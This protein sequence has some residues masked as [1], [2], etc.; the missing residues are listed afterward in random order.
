MKSGF[1]RMLVVFINV[2]CCLPAV[3]ADATEK[4]VS[5]TGAKIPELA[6]FDRV[7][8]DMIRR[9]GFPG[10][11]FA[12]AKDGRLLLAHGYGMADS[13]AGQVMTPDAMF[14]IASLSKPITAAV[15]LKLVAAGKLDLDAKVLNLLSA[16]EPAGKSIDPRWRQISVRQL[17]HHTAGFDRQKSFDP[18]CDSFRVARELGIPSP[19]DQA[20][21]IRL[22]LGRPLDFDPGAKYVYSNF[23]YCLLGRVIEKRTG[24]RYDEATQSLVLVPAGITR[25]RLGQTALG[26]RLP[27][28]VRYQAAHD[29]LGRSVFAD[30][31]EKVAAPYGAFYVEAMDSHGGWVASAIDLARFVTAVDGR[32]KPGLFG[33]SSIE[34]LESPPAAPL[35]EDRRRYYGL[36]WNIVRL[37][38]GANWV[39][40]GRLPGC[41]TM[42]VRLESGV[43]WVALFNRDTDDSFF[44][45]LDRALHD[46]LKQV[47]R[48]P[49]RDYFAEYK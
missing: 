44:A 8:I 47:K 37:D 26:Q 16:H 35:P 13:E 10:G 15:V 31:K 33:T 24:K 48:W 41:V 21:I 40:C 38:H 32:R 25:M 5:V 27:G 11:A 28:E 4:P 36:G 18:M 3:A 14:R 7:M 19:P 2:A 1:L 29:G 6:A 20:A 12:L 23:G 34:L 30:V 43:V 46:A 39:H 45:E 17:L 42:M 22:M 9:H 49:E